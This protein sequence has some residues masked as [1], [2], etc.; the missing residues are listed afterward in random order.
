MFDE[1]YL[2]HKKLYNNLDCEEFML[3]FSSPPSPPFSFSDVDEQV[4]IAFASHR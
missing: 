1:T 3:S 2:F 4:L